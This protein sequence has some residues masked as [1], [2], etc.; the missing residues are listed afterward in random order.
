[1]N[2]RIDA[3]QCDELYQGPLEILA[4]ELQTPQGCEDLPHENMDESCKFFQYIF[5]DYFKHV[6]FFFSDQIVAGIPQFNERA[7]VSAN[8]VWGI[9]RGLESFSQLVYN[10]KENGYQVRL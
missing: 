10:K 1:M 9:L 5:T 2:S 4:V 8:T 6:F 3:S 7:V